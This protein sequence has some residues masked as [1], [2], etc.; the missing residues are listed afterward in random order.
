MSKKSNT[1]LFMLGATVFNILLTLASFF[2]ILA[3]Y[4][5]LLA[6]HLSENAQ[7]WGLLAVFAGAIALAF[8]LYRLIIRQ[9]TKRI[10]FD[11][12]FDPLFSRRR[13]KP[14]P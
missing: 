9:L 7:S 11:K 5:W 8:V 2:G 6:P 3:L 1:L 14:R 10:D 13:N 12:Y 4:A